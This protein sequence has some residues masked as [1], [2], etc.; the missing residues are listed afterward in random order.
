MS[1]MIIVNSFKL[2]TIFA[3]NFIF[4]GFLDRLC[5]AINLLQNTI[6]GNTTAA[7]ESVKMFSIEFST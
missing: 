7:K 5:T 6:K 1:F 3:K 4:F 2:F